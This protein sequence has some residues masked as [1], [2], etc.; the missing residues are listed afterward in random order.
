[1]TFII[2]TEIECPFCGESFTITVDTS[3][4][5]HTMI[6]DCTVCCRPMNIEIE[7]NVGEVFNAQTSRA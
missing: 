5:N 3:Q 4:G 2:D 7:C 1:M 6:E